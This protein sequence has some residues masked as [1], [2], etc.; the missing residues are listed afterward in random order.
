MVLWFANP[1]DIEGYEGMPR[2]L[3]RFGLSA[4]AL[5]ASLPSLLAADA[6]LTD[7]EEIGRA[8]V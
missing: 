6:W 8:H 1:P 3:V 4:M 5:L 2:I 7:L